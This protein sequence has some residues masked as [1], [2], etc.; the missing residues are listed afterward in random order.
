LLHRG[1][2]TAVAGLCSEIL[3]WDLRAKAAPVKRSALPLDG[4]T[5]PVYSMAIT[6][7]ANAHS[8]TSVS[9]GTNEVWF[10]RRCST[11]AI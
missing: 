5:H 4:H 7:T 2:Y 6:G 11:V 3:L 8:L 10:L 9:T 1:P